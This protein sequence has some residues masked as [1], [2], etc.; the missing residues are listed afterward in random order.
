LILAVLLLGMA[1]PLHSQV[2]V[3]VDMT[4]E[5]FLPGEQIPVAV[6][7]I[8]RSGQKLTLGTTEDWLTFSLEERGATVVPKLAEVP[9]L[10]EFA[11]ESGQRGTK[12]VNLEPYFAL[13]KPARYVVVASVQIPAWG[14]E[15]SSFPRY[16]DVIEGTRLWEQTVG[17]PLSPDAT[18][19]TPETRIYTLQ[20]ANYLKG[21]IRLYLRVTDGTTGRVVKL[22]PIGGLLS[23]SRPEAQVDKISQLHLIYQ[24]GP[25]TFSHQVFSTEGELI[26]RQNYD[27][28]DRRPRLKADED[29]WIVVNGGIRRIVPTDFPPGLE[30]EKKEPAI[31][32]LEAKPSITNAPTEKKDKSK[33]K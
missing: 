14:R 21:Q 28:V 1:L 25:Q 13:S 32:D 29:G 11:L 4:Q 7:V 5:Q 30:P 33:K 22:Q 31:P 12:H 27:Y 24:N 23:F 16:F 6:R 15:V 10:G 2:T 19:A 20:Q 18:N 9:V 3:E 8:N 17:L 26:L